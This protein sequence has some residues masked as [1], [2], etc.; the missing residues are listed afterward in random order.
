M[1][2]ECQGQPSM[3]LRRNGNFRCNGMLLRLETAAD[4]RVGFCRIL[5]CQEIVTDRDD[6]EQN[7]RQHRQRNQFRPPAHTVRF[8]SAKTPN[9]PQDRQTG[10]DEIERQFHRYSLAYS[11]TD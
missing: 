10:P 3:R 1:T 4:A 8:V 5:R 6:R 11:Q 2:E 7:K 9:E